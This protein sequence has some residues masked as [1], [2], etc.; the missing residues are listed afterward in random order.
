MYKYIYILYNIYSS[1][2]PSVSPMHSQISSH[3]STSSF[4]LTSMSAP[5]T[6][7]RSS[8][9]GY[10]FFPRHTVWHF[11]SLQSLPLHSTCGHTTAPGDE[12][13]DASDVFEAAEVLYVTSEK[14]RKHGMQKLSEKDI[15]SIA[16]RCWKYWKSENTLKNT[17]FLSRP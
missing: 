3:L 13:D 17:S 6:S 12:G 5:K 11:T 14:T 15:V 9:V 16:E 8:R 10:P 2:I 1:F 4:P 7:K